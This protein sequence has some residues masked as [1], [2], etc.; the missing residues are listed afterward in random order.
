[1]NG[2]KIPDQC[3]LYPH[4]EKRWIND[5]IGWG[6]SAK[7]DIIKG[8]TVT[9]ISGIT[10]TKSKIVIATTSMFNWLEKYSI[11]ID[12]DL[13]IYPTYPLNDVFYMNHSCN[14][15]I[16]NGDTFT[17]VAMRDINKGEQI[18]YDYATTDTNDIFE[19]GEMKCFCGSI[20]C[21]KVITGD[22]WIKTELQEKY[23]GYF[24]PHIQRKVDELKQIPG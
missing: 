17:T 7:T 23:K 15:N 21:R 1:M 9:I 5:K 16:G 8:E 2:L 20:N 18:T 11:E 12:E 22:D 10:M 6:L 3:W 14:P 24:Q 4:I 19:R 13:V